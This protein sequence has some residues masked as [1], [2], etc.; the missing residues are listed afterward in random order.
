MLHNF[1]IW[2][3]KH[4][5]L[6][7]P[8]RLKNDYYEMLQKLKEL[9][10]QVEKNAKQLEQAKSSFLK[11]IYHEIRTPLNSI[12]G[13]TNL[14]AKDYRIGDKE[15]EEYLG[16]INKS[17]NDFLRTMDDIIQASLLEAGMIKIAKE[18]CNL[19]DF[20][21]DLLSYFTMRKHLLGK[22]CVALLMNIPESYSDIELLCDKYRLNQVMGHLLENALKFT[23][24]GSVE[25]GCS[26]KNQKIEFF[27]KDTGIGGIDNKDNYIFTRF[28]KIELAEG[29][30]GGLGLGLSNSKKLL[31]LMGG[32]IW[33][34]S[35]KG[36]GSC[37]FF[38]IPFTAAEPFAVS[39]SRRNKFFETV[40]KG[41]NTLAV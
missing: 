18:K 12:M 17:S 22:N 39:A 4:I 2:L 36:K 26:I 40:I 10:G 29:T 24:K 1:R 14:L 28:S 23:D 41:Q 9:E 8:N 34:S 35:N 27:V 33:C 32:K 38:A 5:H 25:F 20:F 13:F 19:G 21:Q 31:D 16:F 15:R 3:R 11:N 30:K 6:F 7:P 37:F